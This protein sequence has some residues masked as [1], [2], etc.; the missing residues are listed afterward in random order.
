M[1]LATHRAAYAALRS[2]LLGSF[3][4]NAPPPWRAIPPYVSTMILRPVNPQSPTG[5]PITNRPVGL[6]KNSLRNSAAIKQL[7]RQRRQH[8]LLPQI[9]GDPRLEPRGMLRGDQH[10]LDPHRHPTAI[11]HRHLRLAVRTQIVQRPI[12]THVRQAFG[13]PVRQRDRQRHQLRR[14]TGRIPKHHPLIARTRHQQLITLRRPRP[15]LMRRINPQRDIRRLLINRIQHRT[16][17]RRKPKIRIDITNP[18]N[19]IPHHTLNIHIRLS[20]DLPRH[21]NQPR[22]HK[23]LTRHTRQRIIRQTRI[24]HPIR[25]LIGNLIRMPLRHRLRRKQILIVFESAH[26]RHAIARRRCGETCARRSR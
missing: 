2:T 23:R 4:L 5:P 14:L 21:H 1:F 16:R 9:V 3:P 11:A 7:R 26:P 25:N 8:D 6:T 15:R 18:P 22:I 19:R 13:E 10:L 20:R 24:Q 12:V 17:I